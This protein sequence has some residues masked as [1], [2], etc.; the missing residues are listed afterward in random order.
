MAT[1]PASLDDLRPALE[2]TSATEVLHAS[3][4]AFDL[5]LRVADAVTWLDGVDELRA[6]AAA[7]SCAAGRALLPLPQS[8]RPL[9][10]PEHPA[11]HT[12]SCAG[13]LRDVHRALT[14]L[15]RAH[16]T[17]DADDEVLLDAAA[18]AAD[19][20]TALDGLGVV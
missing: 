16:P 14:D 20:A 9:P 10:L 7:R 19:A 17:P 18:L 2:S 1:P 4:E 8:G 12:D 3:W 13:V 5:S 11:A 6:L 15:A